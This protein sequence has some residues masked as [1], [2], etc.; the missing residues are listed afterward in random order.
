MLVS[1]AGLVLVVLANRSAPEASADFLRVVVE[2][3]RLAT[4]ACGVSLVLLARGVWQGFADSAR[5]AM[6]L[7]LLAAAMVVAG[8]S[9]LLAAFLLL[10]GGLLFACCGRF[11]A[12]APRAAGWQAPLWAVLLALTLASSYWLIGRG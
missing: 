6:A 2:A 5:W 1:A 9:G 8:G 3:S 12:A 7:L 4:L 11:S 10:L